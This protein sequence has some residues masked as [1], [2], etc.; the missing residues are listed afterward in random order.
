MHIG[1]ILTVPGG[2]RL[3]HTGSDFRRQANG[4]AASTTTPIA[5]W[6]LLG[7]NILDRLRERLQVFGVNEISV[8]SEQTMG[9]GAQ[10]TSSTTAF[11]HAWNAVIAQYLQL[12]LTTLLLLRVGPYLELDIADLVRFH[13]ETASPMT[14]VYDSRSALDVVAVDAKQLAQG[15]GSFRTR[16]QGLIPKHGRY[17]FTGY[18]NRLVDVRDFHRL[19]DDALCGRAGIRPIGKEIRANVWAGDNARIDNSAQISAPAYIGKHSKICPNC[20]ITGTTTIEQNCEIDS[21]TT[22]DHSCI[23]P[24]SY[25]GPGLSVCGGVVY[26]QTFFHLGRN[27]QLQFRDRRLFGTNLPGRAFL[28]HRR[29]S[30]S[31]VPNPRTFVQ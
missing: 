11:W 31:Q 15:S 24:G 9:P 30:M 4:F 20:I 16:L 19:V 29:A 6:D 10:L 14:Q 22:I 21:G 25:V 7:K 12:D 5:C 13:R 27:V 26:Q 8:I 28:S 2:V 17:P 3:H 23:L 18:C 1:A